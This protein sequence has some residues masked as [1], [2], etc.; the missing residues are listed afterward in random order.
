MKR[1]AARTQSEEE[2]EG[3]LLSQKKAKACYRIKQEEEKCILE[4]DVENILTNKVSTDWFI[5]NIEG[6]ERT[7]STNQ[8]QKMKRSQCNSRSLCWIHLR[9]RLGPA[10]R[11]VAL[12]VPAAGEVYSWKHIFKPAKIWVHIKALRNRLLVT[13]AHQNSVRSRN[14]TRLYRGCIRPS[15]K[16]HIMV[17]QP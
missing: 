13:P 16:Q 17:R 11:K 3:E 4:N 6:N 10:W 2:P 12:T 7:Y 1:Q 5:R 8:F 15:K 14:L 9:N